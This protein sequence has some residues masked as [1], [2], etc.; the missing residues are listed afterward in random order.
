MPIV[1]NKSDLKV[2]ERYHKVELPC[3]FT[4]WIEITGYNEETGEYNYA[5]VAKR[6]TGKIELY[7]THMKSTFD[8]FF[9]PTRKRNQM[10]FTGDDEEGARNYHECNN[11]EAFNKMMSDH[12]LPDRL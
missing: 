1:Q 12:E 7:D 6:Y 5:N 3:A 11:T 4:Q 2:G 9:P 10:F 8:D